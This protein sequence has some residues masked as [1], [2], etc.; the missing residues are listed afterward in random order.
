MKV[1]RSYSAS[2]VTLMRLR[3]AHRVWEASAMVQLRN[4]LHSSDRSR[5]VMMT[6]VSALLPSQ[7][8]DAQRQVICL[9]NSLV[10]AQNIIHILSER[11]TYQKRGSPTA[12]R[13][14]PF[15]VYFLSVELK[16]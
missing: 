14:L 1:T 9:L 2:A 12:P 6:G 11:Y 16:R 3:L 7:P 13:P 15:Y 10:R 4:S 5:A 8:Q